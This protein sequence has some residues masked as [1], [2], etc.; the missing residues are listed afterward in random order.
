MASIFSSNTLINNMFSICKCLD[1]VPCVKEARTQD[2]Y[3]D[4]NH[5]IHF[6][7]NCEGDSDAEWEEYFHDTK[8]EVDNAAVSHWS[9]LGIVEDGFNS[10]WQEVIIFGRWLTT[11]ESQVTGW[12]KS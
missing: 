8:V 7:D 1:S 10:R 9:K 6:V 3:K 5:C 11:D 12:Y 2:A 4:L